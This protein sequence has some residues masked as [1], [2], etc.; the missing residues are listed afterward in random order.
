MSNV[1]LYFI[2][3]ELSRENLQQIIYLLQILKNS[4]TIIRIS[5]GRKF[6]RN[7]YFGNKC[8]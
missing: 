1:K 5:L 7:E 6:I 4:W 8:E 3:F 2:K